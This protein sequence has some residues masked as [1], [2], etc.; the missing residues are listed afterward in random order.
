MPSGTK[1]STVLQRHPAAVARELAEK[2]KTNRGRKMRKPGEGAQC[3]KRKRNSS[4]TV[5]RE[6]RVFGSAFLLAVR[7]GKNKTLISFLIGMWQHFCPRNVNFYNT[8]NCFLQA[9]RCSGAFSSH[10]LTKQCRAG[11]RSPRYAFDHPDIVQEDFIFSA[12]HSYVTSSTNTDTP[13]L[14]FKETDSTVLM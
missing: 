2:S 5:S 14:E 8:Y 11:T 3:E 1:H 6:S 10:R 9:V 12:V 4:E 7:I 13:N